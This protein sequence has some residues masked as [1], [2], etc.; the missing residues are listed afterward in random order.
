[1]AQGRTGTLNQQ[2]V[3]DRAP[4]QAPQ[5]R[6]GLGFAGDTG[7][8]QRTMWLPPALLLL[9]LPGC[10]SLGGPSFVRGTVGSSLTVRC[11]YEEGYKGYNKYWCRGEHDTNC[12]KIVETD[13]EERER[14]NGRVSI[15]DNAHTRTL[16]VTMRNLHAADAGSYW[17]KI[18]TVWILDV[19]SRDPSF[20]VQVSVS[21]APLRTTTR[22]APRPTAPATLP[23]ATSGRNFSAH[24][25]PSSCPGVS[26]S[27]GY[28]LLLLLLKVALLL[29]ALGALVFVSRHPA[30]PGRRRG[31]PERGGWPDLGDPLHRAPAPGNACPGIQSFRLNER[32]LQA[33][34][35][36][37]R[38]Q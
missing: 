4:L 23:E 38:R 13:G 36:R 37:A 21:P 11:W 1:M 27:T 35:S 19:W 5:C 24:R 25:V 31:Q 28:F 16:T 6:L 29:S 18:Q 12:D 9:C 26:L 22:P 3:N 34:H 32:A 7:R 10:L 17:C 20:R 2:R 8:G 14:R 15:Q 30:G 33:L